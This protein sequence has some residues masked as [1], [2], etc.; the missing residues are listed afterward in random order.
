MEE[1]EE[2]EGGGGGRW[3]GNNSS[4]NVGHICHFCKCRS[5]GKPSSHGTDQYRHIQ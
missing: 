4:V 3:R 5:W 2:E 1:E